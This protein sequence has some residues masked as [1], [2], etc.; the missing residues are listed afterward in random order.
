MNLFRPALLVLF[1]LLLPAE[2]LASVG[3]RGN[4]GNGGLVTL[5]TNDRGVPNRFTIQWKAP[6]EQPGY[7]FTSATTDVAPFDTAGPNRL[8]DEGSYGRVLGDGVRAA[9][10]ARVAGNRKS[11]KLWQGIFTVTVRVIRG[12]QLLDRC[13]LRT[14]WGVLRQG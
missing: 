3:Y 9:F 5:R 7:S 2:A 13:H 4:S 11:R 6:C 8:V 14:R 12:D 1:L 10:S